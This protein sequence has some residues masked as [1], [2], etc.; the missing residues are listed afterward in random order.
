[1][2]GKTRMITSISDGKVQELD[3]FWAD[4]GLLPVIA[5]EDKGISGYDGRWSEFSN[6]CPE[7]SFSY[8]YYYA[9]YLAKYADEI[10]KNCGHQRRTGAQER[11]A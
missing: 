3:D 8:F 2:L 7:V 9:S 10:D 6:F 4:S 11:Q 5:E 1:M